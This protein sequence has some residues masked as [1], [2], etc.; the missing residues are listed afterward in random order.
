MGETA[1]AA[2]LSGESAIA[3]NF[4]GILLDWVSG[5]AALAANVNTNVNDI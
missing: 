2:D 4:C 1:P 5:E 3:T